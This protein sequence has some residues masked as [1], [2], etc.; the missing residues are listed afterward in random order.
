MAENP[1]SDGDANT[2]NNMTMDI[3]FGPVP[4][5]RLGHSLGINNIPPKHC[6][7]ACVYCQVGPTRHPE[8]VPRPFYPPEEIRRQVAQRL[9]AVGRRGEQVDYLTFVPDGEP[10]LDSRLKEA[11]A[12]LKGLGLPIAVISNAS[13]IWRPEVRDALMGADWVSLKVDSVHEAAWRQVNRPHD[14]LRLAP[15]LEGVR[16]FA[17]TFGGTLVC[18]TMLI[19]HLND[20]EAAMADLGRFLAGTGFSRACLAVPIR[21]P[22]VTGMRGPDE[23]VL[24][25]AHEQ[26]TGLGLD[27][28]LL[29]GHEGEDFAFGGDLERELLAITA[30]HPLRQS[31]LEALLAKAGADWALV[32]SLL[33]NGRLRQ[34]AYAGDNFYVRPVAHPDNESP[35]P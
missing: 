12:G 22:A 21:P 18:E 3:A 34:V 19:E 13:L 29:T 27:V 8:I 6:S 25:R 7:Y 26:W 16:A 24:T 20:D 2:G 31:A 35:S 33:Q 5:R 4:S 23:S 28:E 32:A 14:S 17:R 11:I 10:T 30:V 15:I 1:S 9:E